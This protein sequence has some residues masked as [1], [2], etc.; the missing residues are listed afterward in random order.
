MSDVNKLIFANPEWLWLLSAVV[1]IP[2][3]YLLLRLYRSRK[4]K[5]FG[6]VAVLKALMPDYSGARGWIKITLFS[7]LAWP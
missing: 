4:L 6:N 1:A 2:I 7:S 3:V 5:S